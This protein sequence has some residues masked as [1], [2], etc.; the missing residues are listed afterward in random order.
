MPF[1]YKYAIEIIRFYRKYASKIKKCNNFSTRKLCRHQPPFSSETR[2]L[3]VIY[4]MGSVYTSTLDK[5]DH[6]LL[7][8]KVF[9]ENF[10]IPFFEL[11]REVY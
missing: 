5:Y 11:C 4:I 10:T 7:I 6:Y 8:R 3:M 9:E 1:T 2:E